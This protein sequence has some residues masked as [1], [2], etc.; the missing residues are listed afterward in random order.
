MPIVEVHLSNIEEREDWRRH[1]VIADVASLPR[2]RQGPRR[3]PRGARVPRRGGGANEHAPRDAGRAARRA[4]ARHR[5]D[6]RPLPDR[7]STA[8]MR[9]CSSCPAAT[10]RSTRTSATSSRRAAIAGVDGRADEALDP[11]GARRVAA[12]RNA[13][14][15]RCSA[16]RAVAG[17]H[18]RRR[19]AR[20]R[21]AA[22]SRRCGRSRT[23]RRSRSCAVR[24]RSP[25]A[26]SRP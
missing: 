9:R 4:A 12:G 22:S 24:R 10:R 17:A 25:T 20:C 1:S 14:G 21:P 15:G 5:P 3:L 16:V 6:E 7:A 19:K 18:G 2:D 23:R 11:A 26:C 13:G 8:R